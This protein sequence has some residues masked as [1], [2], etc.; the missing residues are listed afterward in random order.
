MKRVGV[1]VLKIFCVRH[2]GSFRAA[3]VLGCIPSPEKTKREKSGEAKMLMYTNVHCTKQTATPPRGQHRATVYHRCQEHCL[4]SRSSPFCAGCKALSQRITHQCGPCS[5]YSM[6]TERKPEPD[7]PLRGRT[8]QG[9]LRLQPPPEVLHLGQ[10][11]PQVRSEV[12]HLPRSTDCANTPLGRFLP[13]W[14]PTPSC[15]GAKYSATEP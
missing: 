8:P 1:P 10:R 3:A 7:P 6:R 2:F 9:G 5:H 13:F 12:S 15:S 4:S 11:P 14:T